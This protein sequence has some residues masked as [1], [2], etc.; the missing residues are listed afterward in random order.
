M[1]G[2]L[3]DGGKKLQLRISAYNFL[4]HPIAYPDPV[5]NLTLGFANGQLDDPNGD[6]GKKPQDTKYGRR[7]AQLALRFIF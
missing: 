5:T 4:N 6:F 7:I 2:T 1:H 3:G